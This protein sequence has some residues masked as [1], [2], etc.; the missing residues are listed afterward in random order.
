MY[1]IP[2]TAQRLGVSQDTVRRRIKDGKLTATQDDNGIW[3]VEL[4]DVTPPPAPEL[5]AEV[6]ALKI[7]I[8]TLQ[9]KI[10][11]K[12]ALIRTLEAEIQRLDTDVDMRR[13]EVQQLHAMLYQKAL[14]APLPWWKRLLR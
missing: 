2:Q 10:E 8:A 7:D 11:G 14:T 12:D 5:S 9:A 4:P 1:T 6:T 13:Q 3:Q